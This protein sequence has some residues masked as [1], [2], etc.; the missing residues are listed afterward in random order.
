LA[1]GSLGSM[2]G[3]PKPVDGLSDAIGIYPV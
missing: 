1:L 2:W 3:G